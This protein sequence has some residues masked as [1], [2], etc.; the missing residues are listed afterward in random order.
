LGSKLEI[1]SR[2]CFKLV[3]LTEALPICG[4]DKTIITVKAKE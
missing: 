1:N 4:T 3:A 2:H